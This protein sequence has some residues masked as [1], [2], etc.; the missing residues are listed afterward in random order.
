MEN[1]TYNEC[2]REVKED[3]VMEQSKL[4]ESLRL[5]E[6]DGNLIKGIIDLPRRVIGTLYLKVNYLSGKIV[7]P[8][9][10]RSKYLEAKK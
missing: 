8:L 7:K 3:L 6:I 5:N 9:L 2:L 4:E 10:A 1:E